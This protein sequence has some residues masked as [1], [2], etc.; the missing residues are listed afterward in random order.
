[1]PCYNEA[2]CLNRSTFEVF[3]REHRNIHWIFVNDGSKDNTLHILQDIRS[4]FPEQVQVI[5]QQ[6]NAGKAEAVRSGLLLA[7]NQNRSPLI[8]LWDADL[9][10]PLETIPSFLEV[11]ESS[12]TSEMVFGARVKLLGRQ[13]HRKAILHYLGRIFATTVSVLLQL[14]IYDTQCGAKILRASLALKAVL[15]EPFR[16]RRVFDVGILARLLLNSDFQT[17]SLESSIYEFPLPFWKD[18]GGS[19]VRPCDFLKAF[20]DVYA[21]WWH[22]LRR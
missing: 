18:V 1:M 20:I 4:H 7:C 21:I 14:P 19:K 2:L 8:G 6:P 17:A 12:P 16:S 9:A 15:G 5:D 11:L 10:T 22:Y 3:F 13:V